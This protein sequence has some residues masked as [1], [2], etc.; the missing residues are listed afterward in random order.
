MSKT[1]CNRKVIKKR[2][3]KLTSYMQVQNMY[4][5]FT[6]KFS[7]I[8]EIDFLTWS[9]FRKHFRHWGQSNTYDII[10]SICKGSTI[11]ARHAQLSNC[12]TSVTDSPSEQWSSPRTIYSSTPKSSMFFNVSTDHNCT[13]FI[14]VSSSKAGNTSDAY[15]SAYVITL[16]CAYI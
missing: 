5:H 2:C 16:V 4:L 7:C 12:L 15:A 11:E 9:D 13:W 8:N 6:M 1:I 10:T 14:I 3:Y